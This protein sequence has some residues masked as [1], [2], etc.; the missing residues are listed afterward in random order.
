MIY[1]PIENIS[2]IDIKTASKLNTEIDD[3]EEMTSISDQFFNWSIDKQIRIAFKYSCKLYDR[4]LRE[5]KIVNT[6]KI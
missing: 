5:I 4:M 6:E 3:F 1:K 2:I